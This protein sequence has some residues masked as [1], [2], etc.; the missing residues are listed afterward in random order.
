MRIRLT[1]FF[2]AY[3]KKKKL[4][5]LKN[6]HSLFTRFSIEFEDLRTYNNILLMIFLNQDSFSSLCKNAAHRSRAMKL[7]KNT[8]HL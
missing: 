1:V 7:C 8:T 3:G 5:I 6:F 4:K 2:I